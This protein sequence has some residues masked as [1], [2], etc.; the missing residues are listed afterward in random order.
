MTSETN[1]I[2]NNSNSKQQQQQQQ[3]QQQIGDINIFKELQ[4]SSSSPHGAGT[5][6]VFFVQERIVNVG[7]K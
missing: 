4:L 3:Q 7:I 5:L 6:V 2:S 1:D